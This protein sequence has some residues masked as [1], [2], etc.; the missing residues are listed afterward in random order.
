MLTLEQIRQQGLEALRKRLG[1]AGMVRFL[2][3]FETGHGN[4]ALDRH[5][6]VDE[7]TL[8]ELRSL[9]KRP[10]AGRSRGKRSQP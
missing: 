2:Q 3:Q 9:S 1:R 4:Y 7:T 6:W 10:Q 5:A 8:A